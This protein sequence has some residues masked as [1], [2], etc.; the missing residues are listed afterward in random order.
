MAY[1]SIFPKQPRIKVPFSSM[2][3]LLEM[4][5]LAGLVFMVLMIIKV[6][7]ILPAVIPSHF[8]ALGQPDG[9]SGKS[10][11]IMLP[12]VGLLLYL[13][14]GILRFFPHVYNYPRPITEQNAEVQYRLAI[15]LLAWLKAQIICSFVYITWSTIKLV[16]K[17]S[18]GLGKGFLIVMLSAIFGTLGVYFYRA[19]RSR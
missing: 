12:V 11:L 3:V 10:S 15:N 8:N 19:F 4:V 7:G 2:E 9:Y 1:K 6:W 17:Q 5:S 14:L 13:M 18:S 16:L